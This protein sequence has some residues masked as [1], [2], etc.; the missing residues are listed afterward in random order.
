MRP[1]N[2]TEDMI[3]ARRA[4]ERKVARANRRQQVAEFWADVLQYL[5]YDP[6]ATDERGRL[7]RVGADR[8]G[9]LRQFKWL[10]LGGDSVD[11][12]AG[13]N[14][15]AL[16]AATER[17]EAA[18]ARVSGLTAEMR[19]L[20]A[21]FEALE[22]AIRKVETADGLMMPFRSRLK[23]N[24]LSSVEECWPAVGRV[25]REL[26]G[27]K[28]VAAAFA[29]RKSWAINAVVARET[30][31]YNWPAPTLEDLSTLYRVEDNVPVRSVTDT[32]SD[33]PRHPDTLSL[34]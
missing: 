4:D 20:P 6:R 16:T 14:E 9:E 21:V 15:Q 25:E 26:A 17:V 33:R 29:R 34:F 23:A 24:G 11:F 19:K 30:E 13:W 5:R 2:V 1:I 32:G 27:I 8:K 3:A 12:E 7:T 22:N 18:K 28:K 10:P 31:I